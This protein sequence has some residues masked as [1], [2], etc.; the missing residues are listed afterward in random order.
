MTDHAS[1]AKGQAKGQSVNGHREVAVLPPGGRA[2][3]LTLLAA[4]ANTAQSSLALSP[5]G[6]PAFA[7]YEAARRALREAVRVDEVA[8]I[9]AKVVALEA[10]AKQAK[11]KELIGYAAELR[12]RAE[13]LAGKMLK[14]MAERG[15]RHAGKGQSRAVLP[16]QPDT[17]SIATLKD[18]GISNSQSA[19]WQRRAALTPAEFA[20]QVERAKEQAHFAIGRDHGEGPVLAATVGA[21]SA[22]IKKAARLYIKDG[23]NVA[24]VTYGRG[25]FWVETD[26]T[27]FHLHRSDLNPATPDITRADLRALPYPDNS[28]DVEV[29]DPP[30][31]TT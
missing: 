26:L 19:R 20:A 7:L 17:V 30:M 12:L 9:R 24:D 28:L 23:D 6:V 18:L 25:A 22:M 29:L 13:R 31:D 21:N 14:E 27:H 11:D 5:Q 16:S 3:D 8:L 10:Y 1:G 15:E 2:A 4:K